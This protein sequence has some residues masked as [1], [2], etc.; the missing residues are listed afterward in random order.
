MPRSYAWRTRRVNASWPSSRC[1]R[2]P[3][4]PVPKASRVTF[5]LVLPRVTQSVASLLVGW[6]P[7]RERAAAPKVAARKSRRV[8]RDIIL[9][10]GK[11]C[12][13][14]PACWDMAA[15]VLDHFG[16]TRLDLRGGWLPSL[17]RANPRLAP[18]KQPARS[19][20]SC[21]AWRQAS[22]AHSLQL[23]KRLCRPTTGFRGHR[24]CARRAGLRPPGESCALDRE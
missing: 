12:I 6:A 11:H 20:P 4:V 17:C 8:N 22:P 13:T 24:S 21:P 10:L 1:T 9:L 23:G 2:P 15:M 16:E 3:N 7:S 19:V 14:S 18:V 5:T